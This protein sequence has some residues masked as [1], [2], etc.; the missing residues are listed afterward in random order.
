MKTAITL[1]QVPEALAGPFLLRTPLPEA[2]ATAAMIGFDAVELFLPGPDFVSV[3]EVKSLAAAHGLA[4]AAV[5]TGA[6]MLRHELSIT[7]ADEARRDAALNFVFAMIDFG[8]QLGA[9]AI[10]GSMQGRGTADSLASG[11]RRCG[12][13]AE[14]HSVPFIYEPLN[15]YETNLFNRLGDAAKFLE[16]HDLK[17]VVLLADLFHMNIEERDLAAAIREA[18]RHI[19][20]VHYADSN[21]QAM[22]FGHTDPIRVI[23]ALREIAYSGYLSAEIFPL[24]DPETA[25]RQTISSIRSLL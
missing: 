22:G 11:L 6:G 16:L 5:G 15:R 17:N 12:E 10:L 1:S 24:P 2:F 21:R 14:K 7:D 13:R 8:G 19:G 3:D 20:H 25:A 23:A 4:I 9:P 18:G